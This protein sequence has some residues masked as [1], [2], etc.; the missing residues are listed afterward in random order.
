MVIP[1]VT[2]GSGPFRKTSANT[3]LHRA[4]EGDWEFRKRHF[5]P[6]DDISEA[7]KHG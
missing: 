7:V 1:S 2:G 6:E 3:T 4:G 5:A